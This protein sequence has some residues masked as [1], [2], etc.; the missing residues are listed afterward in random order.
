[1]TI[2]TVP[3]QD[4]LLN[5]PHRRI[6]NWTS[7]P[8]GSSRMN[9]R[10]RRPRRRAEERGKGKQGLSSICKPEGRCFSDSRH[11][12]LPIINDKQTSGGKHQVSLPVIQLVGK[13]KENQWMSV[14]HRKILDQCCRRESLSHRSRKSNRQ[15]NHLRSLP[16]VRLDRVPVKLRSS[17]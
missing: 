8:R 5:R 17:P 7:R 2:R 16:P 12:L 11:L 10:L 3:T 4:R 14:Q 1:M 9:F 6:V 15:C 13:E